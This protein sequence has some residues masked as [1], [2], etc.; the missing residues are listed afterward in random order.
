MITAV[1]Q[2]DQMVAPLTNTSEVAETIVT[3]FIVDAL[4][5][6]LARSLQAIVHIDGLSAM[7]TV[8]PKRAMTG[9]SLA[10]F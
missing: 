4:S 8:I 10:T 2:I 3:V 5:T 7:K 9:F 1:A 6:F